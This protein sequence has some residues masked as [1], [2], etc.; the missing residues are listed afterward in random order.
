M[1]SVGHGT[2]S[3]LYLSVRGGKGKALA[4]F[5]S[6]VPVSY[7]CTVELTLMVFCALCIFIGPMFYPL[8]QGTRQ[9]TGW[10]H[11]RGRQANGPQDGAAKRVLYLAQLQPLLA[12]I[13]TLVLPAKRGNRETPPVLPYRTVAYSRREGVA[14]DRSKQL[15]APPHPWLLL[16]L[17]PDS[18][19]ITTPRNVTVRGA[20]LLCTIKLSI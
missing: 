13:P 15:Q 6:E 3:S 20:S 4:D 18:F 10:L 2:L 9:S 12:A 1:V 8:M 19:S 11:F 5:L 14:R 16:D 7:L 17:Y